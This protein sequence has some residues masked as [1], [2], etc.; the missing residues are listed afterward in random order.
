[1]ATD[2]SRPDAIKP[3]GNPGF[4]EGDSGVAMLHR[5]NAGNHE[6]LSTWGLGKLEVPADA[7]CLDI[8]CGGGANLLR[9]LEL[10][11]DGHV[12]GI[13]HSACAVA[14]S[15]E[16]CAEAIAQGRADVL[17]GSADDLPQGSESLDVVTAFET[18]YFWPDFAAALAEIRRVLKPGGAF[19]ICNEDDGESEAM[20]AF[21]ASRDDMRTYTEA[22]LREALAAAG[23][24]EV[25]VYRKPEIGYLCAIA[26]A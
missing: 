26:R 6:L 5:M 23:M 10:A 1:M 12:T 9:L 16:T 17:E 19:F 4:P 21:V 18:I 7:R 8:G 25:S 3:E 13:D 20:Q 14:T 22:Q 24:R 11:P 2:T 15:R